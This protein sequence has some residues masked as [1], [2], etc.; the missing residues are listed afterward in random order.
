MPER[1]NPIAR[2]HDAKANYYVA[3]L[4]DRLGIG[5]LE[6]AQGAA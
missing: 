1:D 2:R 5:S 3:H 4:M 6:Q